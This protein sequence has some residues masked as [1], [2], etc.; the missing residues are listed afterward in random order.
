MEH[1]TGIGIPYTDCPIGQGLETGSRFTV[2]F[3]HCKVGARRVAL[4]H[5]SSP[6]PPNRTCKFP[7][8]RLSRDWRLPPPV[9]PLVLSG[10]SRSLP[11][12]FR[13]ARTSSSTRQ[14]LDQN[15][16]NPL[17]PFAM[18]AAFPRSDYYG[19]SDAVYGHWWTAH[20]HIPCTASHVHNDEL[21]AIV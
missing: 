8:I 16:V 19:A 21:D 13:L 4:Q 2:G 15:H 12:R 18:C 14:L 17:A 20:L 9:L 3:I 1:P 5:V 11:P 10:S 6:P 7:S